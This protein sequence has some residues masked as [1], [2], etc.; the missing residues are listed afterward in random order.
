MLAVAGALMSAVVATIKPLM[1]QVLN[2]GVAEA[3]GETARASTG[4]DILQAVKSWLPLERLEIWLKDR[5]FVEVPLLIVAVFFVRGIF[6]YFGEYF[7][8]KVGTSVV[9]DVRADLFESVIRQSL[10]FFQAHPS[11]EIL[12]RILND[13][14]RLQRVTTN[15]LA[16]LFRVG[17]MVPF[18]LGVAFLHD[19]RMTLF[20]LVVLP[21]LGYPMV[22][23]GKRLRRASTRSQETLA[24]AAGVLNEAVGGAR[25]VQG[26]AMEWFEIGR[27]RAALERMLRADLKAGRAAALAPSVMELVGATAGAFLF[28]YAGRNIARGVLDPGDFAVV[29]ASLGFLFASIR[30]MNSLNVEIQQALAAATRVFDMMDR[31]RDIRDLPGAK[32]L[33]AFRGEIR[34]DRVTFAYEDEKVLDGI[35]LTLR[36]GEVVALVGASGSGKSTLANMLPRFYDPTEGRILVDGCDLRE[37][38]LASL[39]SQIGLVTQETVLFDDTVRHNIAYGREEAPQERVQAA[40]LAA[41]AQ[42]FVERLP[43]GYDT[44]LGERGAR[45]SMGQRQR[46]AIA[47]ALLKD[48]PILILDEATSALDSESET[49]VQQAL[50][51]LLEGRTALVIAHRLATVRRADRILVMDA[52]RIVEEGTHRELLARGGLYARLYELQF[53]DEDQGAGAVSDEGGSGGGSTGGV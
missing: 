24:E 20:S 8:T 30:R 17:T 28:F 47:R 45:L 11:G 29:L 27:F 48:P 18:M 46:I 43:L 53:R 3:A 16:D 52:G 13:V 15:V 14:Q 41:N 35:E 40:A 4:P 1:N 23:L 7:T 51:V 33:P 31:Q 6:L 44:V 34:F 22:R 25:V 21:L 12:S 38:T 2:P 37:V 49:L 50:E 26:F 5:A 42:Q 10:R 9:R 32:D 39:R 19:W 36:K